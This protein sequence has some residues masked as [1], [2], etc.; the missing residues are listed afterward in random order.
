MPYGIVRGPR[1]RGPPE[2]VPSVRVT[3]FEMVCVLGIG[4]KG[5]VLLAHRKGPSGVYALKVIAKRRVLAYQEPQHTLTEQA[6]LRRMAS[7]GTNSSVVKLLLSFHDED[8][9]YMALEF[10]P[11][12]D[13]RTQ[14][15]RWRSFGHDLCRFYAAELVEALEGLHAA[16]VIHRNLKPEHILIDKDGHIVLCGFGKCRDFRGFP[17]GMNNA[18]T[19]ASLCGTAEY[20]AP[21]VI[22]GLPYSYAVDWWSL[23]TIL[24]EMLTGNRPFDADNMS[25]MYDRILHD[26]LRFPDDPIVDHHTRNFIQK[27]LERDPTLRLAEPQIK[28]HHY[29][30]MIDWSD[31]H[32]RQLRPPYIPPIDRSNPTDTQNFE[33]VYL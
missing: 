3:D 24:Y 13:L 2:A 20:F 21:E 19:T 27:L 12:G 29:F 11:C 26:G 14:L 18:E 9:L 22:K 28:R 8:N 30:L 15:D 32:Y 16:G 4:S 33:D 7:E 23:G 25:D 31:V 1:G 5:K 17:G 10:H 6:V